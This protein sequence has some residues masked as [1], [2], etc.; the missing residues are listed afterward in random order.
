MLFRGGI[1]SRYTEPVENTAVILT[2]ESLDAIITGFGHS[3]PRPHIEKY[4]PTIKIAIEQPMFV[5]QSIGRSN[6][7]CHYACYVG[8]YAHRNQHM[9]VVLE[10]KWYGKMEVV[11]AFFTP[12]INS[13]EKEIWRK[14]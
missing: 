4:L 8:D 11:T 14:S 12:D 3:E 7:H 10:K 5:K 1:H 9:K 6:R 2:Q 13:K